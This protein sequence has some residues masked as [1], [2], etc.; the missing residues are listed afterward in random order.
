MTAE[1]YVEKYR[2][3][4]V[5]WTDEEGI[6]KSGIVDCVGADLVWVKS[7][8]SDKCIN[9]RGFEMVNTG[10]G[11]LNISALVFENAINPTTIDLTR[12]PQTCPKCK[13]PAYFGLNEV[14]CS[15]GCK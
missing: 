8:I 4:K 15:A 10:R 2:G 13:A 9:H 5:C 3:Q 12:Y 1:E 11:R 14:D 6:V 7:V